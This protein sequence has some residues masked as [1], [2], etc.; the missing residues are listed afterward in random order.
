[1]DLPYLVYLGE[2]EA[3]FPHHTAFS[4]HETEVLDP[5]ESPAYYSV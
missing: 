1:M 2:V 4:A 3:D 5:L